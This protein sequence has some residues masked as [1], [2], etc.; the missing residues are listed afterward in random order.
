[1]KTDVHEILQKITN[2]KQGA[3]KYFTTNSDTIITTAMITARL[4]LVT[5]NLTS[6]IFKHYN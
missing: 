4:E 3:I 2:D 6:L 5:S 1:M